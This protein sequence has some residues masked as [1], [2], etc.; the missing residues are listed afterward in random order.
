MGV[1]LLRA[2]PEM[3]ISIQQG[4]LNLLE[5][6]PLRCLNRDQMMDGC[7]PP[8]VRTEDRDVSLNTY[9][10]L[11]RPINECCAVQEPFAWLV[12]VQCGNF[13]LLT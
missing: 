5:R 7:V 2:V 4:T 1:L 8:L 3:W 10:L 13:V 6:F 11:A 9:T 12:L